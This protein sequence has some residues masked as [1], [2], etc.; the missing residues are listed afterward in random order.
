MN[1]SGMPTQ[2]NGEKS[3]KKSRKNTSSVWRW[4]IR[5]GRNY[6]PHLAVLTL[7]YMLQAGFS[8]WFALQ[9]RRLIDSTSREELL[10][11]AAGLL[12]LT[13]TWIAVNLIGNYL[14]EYISARLQIRFQRHVVSVVMTRRY[15]EISHVHSG[16][17]LNYLDSDVNVVTDGLTS[18]VPNGL[19]MLTKLIG[20]AAVLLSI[21]PKLTI[22]FLTAGTALSV[23]LTAFRSRFK[24]RHKQMQEASGDVKTSF[25]ETIGSL[26]ITRVFHKEQ[27]VLEQV[28]QKQAAYFHSRMRRR[29]T[30]IIASSGLSFVFQGGYIA[31]LIW[32]ALRIQSGVLTYGSLIAM[33]QLVSQIQSPISGFSNLVTRYFSVA[34]SAER[35]MALEQMPEDEYAAGPAAPDAPKHTA[36]AWDAQKHITAAPDTDVSKKAAIKLSEQAFHEVSFSHVYFSYGDLPVLKDISFTIRQGEFVSVTGLSGIG[37]STLFLLLLGMLEPTGGKTEGVGDMRRCA[38]YV[39]QEM[40]LF[41]ATIRENVTFF[42]KDASQESEARIWKA[43]KTACADSFV[44]ELPNG[45]DTKLL[46]KGHGL[47]EGQ[48]QRISIARAIYQ[49]R[50][51]LFLDEATSALDEKTEADILRNISH[52]EGRTVL[53]VTHRPAA[54]GICGRHFILKDGELTERESTVKTE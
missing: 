35:L 42:E 25:V 1:N 5:R 45:L 26:L 31:A 44:R 51:V 34:A 3:V 14:D 47:S 23:I 10:R 50:P 52:L 48:M 43:L 46:E 28:D 12:A 2:R 6:L 38:A 7:L 40:N 36:A 24:V 19:Y 8:V 20:A 37:K 21:A 22:L 15:G 54:L 41:A 17:I 27:A 30:G 33:L 9:C 39:P 29:R 53:I 18:I 49:D 11:Q 32:G 4:I 16:D 13:V